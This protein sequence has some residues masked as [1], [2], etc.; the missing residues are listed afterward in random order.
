MKKIILVFVA[1]F[2]VLV[3]G[4]GH[5]TSAKSDEVISDN[6]IYVFIQ[7]GCSHCLAA[8]KYL[9]EKQPDLKVQLK[10]IAEPENLKLFFACG[11]KFKLN[12]AT[13]GTPLFCMGKNYILGWS[14]E[15]QQKFET[16]VQDFLQKETV[17]E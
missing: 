13:M 16:Y 12:K 8:E 10:D 9:K 3:W 7:K 15:E 11:S 4:F 6:E 17:A 14:F 2:T 1:V 5:K